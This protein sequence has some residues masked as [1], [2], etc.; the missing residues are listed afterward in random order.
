MLAD[1]LKHF[2]LT[3]DFSQVGF[4]ES[5]E[6]I[7]VESSLKEHMNLGHF[8]ALTGPVGV[9]K[10][11]LIRRVIGE[12]KKSKGVLVSESAETGYSSRKDQPLLCL[13][14]GLAETSRLHLTR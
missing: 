13:S 2:K 12:L 1:I 9:G 4:Y 8:V 11:T 7:R 3:K 14:L 10:T 6:L 5:K